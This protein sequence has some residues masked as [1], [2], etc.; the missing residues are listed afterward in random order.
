MEPEDTRET[1]TEIEE[2]SA[3]PR[4]TEPS[5]VAQVRTVLTSG[6]NRR[7]FLAAAALGSAAA[8]FV[9]KTGSGLSGFRLGP[10]PAFAD[11]LSQFQC[12]SNDVRILGTGQV[13]NEPCNCTGTFTATVEFTVF[14]N[15][16]SARNCITLHL[17]AAPGVPAQDV[18]LQG[19]I[20]GKTTQKMTGQI[21]NFPCGA[22]LVCFGAAGQDDRGRC[23]PG[24]C[25]STVSWGVP[26]QDTCPPAKQIS[27]KC[28][29]Q[30][31]CVQGRGA[32]TLDCDTSTVG[33]QETCPVTCGDTTTLRLCTTGGVAPFTFTLS[34]PGQPTQTRTSS[35]LCEDFTVGPITATTVFTG[36]VTDS[37]TPP[38]TRS[39]TVTLTVTPVAAPTVSAGTPNCNGAV[40]FTVTNCNPDLTY[41]FQE[42]TDCSATGTPIGLSQSVAGCPAAATF[43]FAPGATDAQH[44]VRVTAHI[45]GS[46]S[47]TCDQVA[48]VC[49]SIPAAVSATLAVQ[50]TTGCNGVVTLL[51]TALGGVGPFTFTFNGA[52]GTVSGTG[53]TRT[54]VIQP[55]LDGVCRSVTVTVTD[56]RGCSATSAAV[57]W[58]SCVTTTLNCTPV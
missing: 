36:A 28:R 24:V 6:L 18:L 7:N 16:N 1:S 35:N 26:G 32:V 44:C 25:C 49:V 10:L 8:A 53:N 33:V 23:D 37:G 42:V 50:G 55:I 51:A 27:S 21:Q 29:H 34:A 38:C 19:E 17:C 22:G 57:S 2:A 14:N 13:I 43:T 41:T 31:I 5:T 48:C 11:D 46:T 47:T 52:T 12:T 58:S 45:T 3:E 54:I 40:T 30:L 9:Q 20:A 4:E 15:A 56:S 39:D